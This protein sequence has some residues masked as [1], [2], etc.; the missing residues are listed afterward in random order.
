MR[1]ALDNSDTAAKP[2][3][4][5]REAKSETGVQSIA[6]AATILETVALAREGIGLADLSKAVGLHS[7]TAFHIAK[8]LHMQGFLR[9]DPET[10]KYRIG[11]RLFSL[12]AGALDEQELLQIARPFLKELSRLSGEGSH[13]AVRVG[14]GVVIVDTVEGGASVRMAERV[15]AQRPW[16]ATA[17]GKVILTGLSEAELAEYLATAPFESF[18]A[19]TITEAEALRQEVETVRARGVA[20]DDGEF[21]PEARCLAAPVIDFRGRVIAAAGIT[22]PVWRLSLQKLGEVTEILQD[23]A[24]RLSLACGHT[25]TQRKGD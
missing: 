20:F 10:K 25:P 3:G 7:S 9:Q 22:A 15:G 5:P 19:K 24:S 6:R 8:T 21:D 11:A 17:I 23:V 12:A 13:V 14:E 4:K 16:H 18:T 2:A 1:D